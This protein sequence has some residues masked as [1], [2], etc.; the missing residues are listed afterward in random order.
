MSKL[1]NVLLVDDDATTNFLN[2]LLLQTMGIADQLLVAENGI[3][4]LRILRQTCSELVEPCPQLIL[5][6]MNMPIMNG[7]AFLE[8]YAQQP[9]VHR[10]PTVIVMLTTSLHERDLVRA[11]ALPIASILNKPLTREKVTAILQTHFA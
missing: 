8:A 2:K 7:L 9:E 11:Q 5:L 10:H 4:A 1:A 6:D 3:E